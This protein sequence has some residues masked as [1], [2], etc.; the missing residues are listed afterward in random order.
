MWDGPEKEKKYTITCDYLVGPFQTE[1]IAR[2][3]VF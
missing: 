1:Q 2:T 3:V